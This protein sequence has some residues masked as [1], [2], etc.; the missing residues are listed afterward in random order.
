MVAVGLID[1]LILKYIID[2]ILTAGRVELLPLGILVFVFVKLVSVWIFSIY[3]V[4]YERFIQ[5]ILFLLRQELYERMQYK[6]YQFFKKRELGDL[7]KLLTSDVMQIRGLFSA[8]ERFFISGL[9]LIV[10][11]S[12][13]AWLNWQALIILAVTIPFYALIQLSYIRKVKAQAIA[14]AESDVRV[15]NFFS[16]RLSNILLIKLFSQ[17]AR[18]LKRERKLTK[19]LSQTNVQLLRSIMSSIALIGTISV[20]ALAVLVWFAGQ[21]VLMGAMTLGVLIALYSYF[22]SLFEPVSALVSTPISVQEIRASLI[23]L[24]DLLREKEEGAPKDAGSVRFEGEIVFE[25]VSFAYPTAPKKLILDNV[26]FTIKPGERVAIAGQSGEGKSTIA[27]LLLRFFEPTKGKIWIDGVPVTVYSPHS[28]RSR[29]GFAPQNSMLFPGTVYENVTY[30][31]PTSR[32]KLTEEERAAELAAIHD[33]IAR[34]PK[35][36]QTI[37]GSS[38]GRLSEGEKQRV[39]LARV[40]LRDQDVYVFDEPTSALD[41]KNEEYI[42]QSIQQVTEGHTTII[43]S[44]RV[45]TIDFADRILLL[46]NGRIAEE[47]SFRSLLR[48]RKKFYGLFS[49]Q[50]RAQMPKES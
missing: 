39:S 35:G 10:I 34:L 43:I 44:H 45:S 6:Q 14:M 3:G 7:I 12:I 50:K 18:E 1:P 25:N 16:E 33:R 46:E 19:Q 23:R 37:V 36:Y 41:K 13:V 17:E 47:G 24:S 15:M 31:M 48:K 20:L 42:K 2:D 26:S 27:L 28:L 4:Q 5:R 22:L 21:S 11:L 38:G 9:K 29:I 32:I 8:G 40:F 30:A 49:E